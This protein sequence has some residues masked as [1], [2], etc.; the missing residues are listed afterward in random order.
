MSLWS[1]ITENLNGSIASAHDKG[2]QVIAILNGISVHLA[3]LVESVTA[4]TDQDEY[5]PLTFPVVCDATGTGSVT[6]QRRPGF[7]SELVSVSA[8]GAA[9]SAG[10]LVYL[11]DESPLNLL[12]AGT[13]NAFFSDEFP[14]GSVAPDGA[15]LIVRLVAAGANAQVG[16]TI[17]SRR[18][19]LDKNRVRNIRLAGESAS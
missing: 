16:V 10:L 14:A 3:D 17:R 1:E 5:L 7:V 9:A 12:Y 8:V 18:K 6:V 19:Q 4:E 11:N 2:D 15:N 13:L